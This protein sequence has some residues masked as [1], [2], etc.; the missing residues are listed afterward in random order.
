[1]TTTPAIAP[2][3][4]PPISSMP[5]SVPVSSDSNT[6]TSA[7]TIAD[8]NDLIEKEWVTQ[9]QKILQQT[10]TDPY[11]QCKLFTELKADYMKKRYGKL[12]KT[13]D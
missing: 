4:D 1:M 10:A 13:G 2:A 12:L 8:D 9:V 5:N 6:V 7:P 3:P 11:E